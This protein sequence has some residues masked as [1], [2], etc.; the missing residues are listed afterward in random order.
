[1]F[2]GRVALD[3]CNP[4]ASAVGSKVIGNAQARQ[5]HSPLVPLDEGDVLQKSTGLPFSQVEVLQRWGEVAQG[6]V[7]VGD[8]AALVPPGLPQFVANTDGQG[9]VGGQSPVVL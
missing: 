5:E 7:E 9:Q 3:H 2:V 1:M 4:A 6:S 8:E